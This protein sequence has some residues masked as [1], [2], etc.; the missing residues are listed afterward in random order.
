MSARPGSGTPNGSS[1]PLADGWQRVERP[2]SLFRRFTFA[3]YAETRAFLDRLAALSQE[4]GTYPDLGFGK[5]YVNVTV[6]GP[7]GAP[8]ADAQ[9]DFARRASAFCGPETA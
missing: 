8:P 7:D 6:Y 2:P 1:T 4:T 9:Y 5:T 3:S